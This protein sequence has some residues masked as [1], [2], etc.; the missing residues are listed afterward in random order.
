MAAIKD[1]LLD[2]YNE[3]ICTSAKMYTNLEFW[4][5]HCDVSTHMLFPMH[6]TIELAK[7]M[8]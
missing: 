8:L 2:I 5:F 6:F 3:C 4:L 1:L 7:K